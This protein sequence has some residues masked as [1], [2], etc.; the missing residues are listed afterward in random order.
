MMSHA[1]CNGEGGATLGTRCVHKGLRRGDGQMTF[2]DELEG[3]GRMMTDYTI[4]KMPLPHP[5][6]TT[7][8]SGIGTGRF[9]SNSR[10]PWSSRPREKT[11]GIQK[12]YGNLGEFVLRHLSVRPRLDLWI[13]RAH[14]ES[15]S[16]ALERLRWGPEML[17][18]LYGGSMDLTGHACSHNNRSGETHERI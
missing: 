13:Q 5:R 6:S 7:T 3:T 1:I 2:I 16:Y 10:V 12:G 15:P 4:P 14:D 8:A 11:L 9:S 18:G 17:E